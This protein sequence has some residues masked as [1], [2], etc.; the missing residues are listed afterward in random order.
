[1]NP[2]N[3]DFEIQTVTEDKFVTPIKRKASF[4]NRCLGCNEDMGETNPR[5]FCRKTYC[6]V[7]EEIRN[8]KRMR[9]SESPFRSRSQTLTDDDY[10]PINLFSG[11]SKIA[12]IETPEREALK[13][14]VFSSDEK[15][16]FIFMR[17]NGRFRAFN[18]DKDSEKGR[19]I[20][21]ILNSSN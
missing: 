4:S 10:D 13:S 14:P 18:F 8:S 20:N 16:I 3:E 7:V 5:Q 12:A 17:V 15:S 11:N 6:P 2:N 19:K 9:I 21:E 1:M